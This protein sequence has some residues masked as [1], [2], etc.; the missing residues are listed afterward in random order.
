MG[1]LLLVVA[2]R[3][4]KSETAINAGVY[5]ERVMRARRLFTSFLDPRIPFALRA[6]LR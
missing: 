4:F 3:A 2:A 5:A 6:S 1:R